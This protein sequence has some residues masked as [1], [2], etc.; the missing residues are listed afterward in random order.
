[1]PTITSI[2]NLVIN[3]V[4]SQAV[5]DAMQQQGKINDNE[6][7]L[8]EGEAGTTYVPTSRTINGKALSSDITLNASDIGITIYN[9]SVV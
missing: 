5:F 2:S 8:I 6:L 4:A 1:M 3:E 7:Y 9:G